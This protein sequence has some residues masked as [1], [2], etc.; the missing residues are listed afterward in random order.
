MTGV[1]PPRCDLTRALI[2]QR[3]DGALSEVERR[4][5]V[6]HTAQCSSCRAFEA[7]SRWFTEA[8]RA[9]PPEPLPGPVSVPSL[10]VGRAWG[11][12]VA[13]VASAAALLVVVVGGFAVG[14][15]SS[16]DG[17]TTRV[18]T[19]AGLATESVFGDSLRALRVEALRAGE[20]HMLPETDPPH[21]K[22]ALPAVDA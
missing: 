20:L 16:V 19:A 17:P 13:N 1:L 11:H 10:R 5:V 14:T 15:R 2:S 21:G 6:R 8:L 4:Q 3:L 22:P 12:A 7:Q 9:T 18:S